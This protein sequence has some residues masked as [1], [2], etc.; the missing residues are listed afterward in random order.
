MMQYLYIFGLLS[1]LGATCQTHNAQ[2]N[3]TYIEDKTITYDEY[4]TAGLQPPYTPSILCPEEMDLNDFAVPSD[5]LLP[6]IIIWDPINQQPLS[7]ITFYCS[8][9]QDSLLKY[10]P[11]MWNNGKRKSRNF[12]PRMLYHVD[13]LI[14]LIGTHYYCE[15]GSH[16]VQSTS[17]EVLSHI[18]MIYFHL[19][20]FSLGYRSGYTTDMVASI[21][22][23]ISSGMSFT[24]LEEYFVQKYAERFMKLQL[25]YYTHMKVF[26]A[27][28]CHTCDMTD[29]LQFPNDTTVKAPVGNSLVRLF[30]QDFNNNIPFYD[31]DM[32]NSDA[33]S[34]SCD[35]TFK[36]SM[37]IGQYRAGKWEKIYDALF[38]VMNEHSEVISWQLTQS[39]KFVDITPMFMELNERLAHKI[40]FVMLDN[41]CQFRSK[42][43]EIFGN[44]TK[45]FLD[46]FHAISRV[47]RHIPKKHLFS[48]E[49]INDFSKIFRSPKDRNT[50][51][52]TCH[53]P[54]KDIMLL[55]LSIFLE[56]Y[57]GLCGTDGS[58][59]LSSKA[60]KEIENLRKHIEKGCLSGIPPKASTSQNENLHRHLNRSNINKC[61]ISPPLAAA[62]FYIFFHKWN[63]KIRLIKN[64]PNKVSGI[65][66]TKMKY[67]CDTILGKDSPINYSNMK[68]KFGFLSSFLDTDMMNLGAIEETQNH[69]QYFD[70]SSIVSQ[71]QKWL[72]LSDSLKD[73]GMNVDLLDILKMSE[74][75][76]QKHIISQNCDS[77]VLGSDILKNNVE[78][79]GLELKNIPGDGNCLLNSVM[80]FVY[81]ICNKDDVI[82]K[83]VRDLGFADEYND[84]CIAMLRSLMV[85]EWINN[86]NEYQNHFPDINIEQEAPQFLL[87]GVYLGSLGDAMLMA[88][89]NVLNMNIF[90]LTSVANMPF[91]IV[92]PRCQAKVPNP[93]VIAY[94]QSGNGHYS[95]VIIP[96]KATLPKTNVQSQQRSEVSESV[97]HDYSSMNESFTHHSHVTNNVKCSCGQRL[98]HIKSRN[99]EKCVPK[100]YRQCPC[101]TAG[102]S[103]TNKCKCINCHN[104]KIK[105]VRRKVKC[106]LKISHTSAYDYM[107][108][109][110][111]KVG[112]GWNKKEV[113]LLIEIY[114]KANDE[115][116]DPKEIAKQFNHIAHSKTS[117]IFSE[118]SVKQI[119]AKLNSIKQKQIANKKSIEICVKKNEHTNEKL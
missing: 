101:V 83:H 57:S 85:N 119:R 92:S 95:G 41:C 106:Q 118:K 110:Q 54:E 44:D 6:R 65:T 103:C 13:G 115:H 68:M 72:D 69:I 35:H 45:V 50:R 87:S 117:N 108:S 1:L 49:C 34:I 39:T 43:M 16:Y 58:P 29:I 93:V 30:L 37:N 77:T 46:L 105:I 51:K 60:L 9:H 98:R 91:L 53:T 4:I 24:Q 5:Y 8:I 56:K 104:S 2:R 90:V 62:L 18:P 112:K 15:K 82:K 86:I 21:R 11:C 32:L 76:L 81:D 97:E 14:H 38:I 113:A 100:S 36:V 64:L 61:H 74:I 52:R 73:I 71:S 40:D 27:S 23:H 22:D 96:H 31:Y 48:K 107:K 89:A 19:I 88:I 55:H 102:Q 63:S 20:P 12:A 3:S 28:F 109:K 80:F 10:V 67:L 84:E 47:T 70:E 94:N 7:H 116:I 114:T 79:H 59:I 33:N 99:I 111:E 75:T 26:Y 78:Q 66:L 17:P 25:N 42:I